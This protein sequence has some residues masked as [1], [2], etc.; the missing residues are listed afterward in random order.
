MNAA[1][2]LWTGSRG[3]R[4]A[5][6]EQREVSSQCGRHRG[7]ERKVA[8]QLRKGATPGAQLGQQ[9]AVAHKRDGLV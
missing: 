5:F 4:K 3:A 7:Y 8:Q 6:L 9:V 1:G 2:P